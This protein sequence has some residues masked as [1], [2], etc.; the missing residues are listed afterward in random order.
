M[1][2]NQILQQWVEEVSELTRPD[3]IHWCTGSDEENR[4]FVNTMLG[5]G[6]F[7]ELNQQSKS[8]QRRA[9][10]RAIMASETTAANIAGVNETAIGGMPLPSDINIDGLDTESVSIVPVHQREPQGRL[11]EMEQIR[12]YLE[13]YGERLPAQMITELDKVA[14]ALS[15]SG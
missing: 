2:T 5:T 7:I 4:Q 12:E 10:P 14:A 9:P 8:W 6:E 11:V 3:N 13:G 1:T 15:A